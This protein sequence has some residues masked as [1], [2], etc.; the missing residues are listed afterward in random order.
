MK[1]RIKTEISVIISII[2][3]IL[4]GIFIYKVSGVTGQEL[5]SSASSNG[6]LFWNDIH[7]GDVVDE[8][9]MEN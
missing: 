6:S 9:G 2:A 4:M 3:I 8:T 7:I 1:M 5:S